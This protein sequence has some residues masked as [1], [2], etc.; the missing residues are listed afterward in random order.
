MFCIFKGK[1]SNTK[2]S[3]DKLV[4]MYKI[5][6]PVLL[7]LVL[8]AIMA[9]TAKDDFAPA[10]PA[11]CRIDAIEQFAAFASD[12]TFVGKHLNP[13]LL[14]FESANGKD[15]T[16]KTPDGQTAKAFELK[17][18]KKTNHYVLVFHEWWGLNN[19]IRQEAEKLYNDL[20]VNVIAVDLYDGK[21]ATE[22]AEAG[23]LMQSLNTERAVAIINGAI[24]Y[25]GKKAKIY[26]IG[27]CLGGGWSLQASLLAGKQAN[28]C[29]IY[30]GM[31]EKDV[32]RLKTLQT[33]VLGIFAG[34]EK[35]ISPEI[36]KEFDA[37]M[38]AA[39]KTLNYKL[40]D[41]DHAFA[42]PSNPKY[43]EEAAEEAYAMSL[44]FL[45]KQIK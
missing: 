26:T 33:E 15:I 18:S 3:P 19:H 23:K 2:F 38:K 37:N 9:F 27:W 30:Y 36:V 7:L 44:S 43:N 45:K 34:Q 14:A 4:F 13:E 31:P 16:F 21:L 17:A 6:L 29:I 10:N 1:Y 39:G 28:G 35:W 24:A 8:S 22:A 41:A 42:N 12:E 11:C 40:F 32:N 25:A 5:A 20:G